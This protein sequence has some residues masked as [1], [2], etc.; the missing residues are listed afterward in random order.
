MNDVTIDPSPRPAQQRV[1]REPFVFSGST[2]EYFGIWIVN[3][4]L[5]IVTLGIYSAWAKVRRQRYFYGNTCLAGATFDYHA[6]PRQILVGR[7]AVVVLFLLYNGLTTVA[8]LAS[9]AVGV[10]FLF[11]VPWFI[12]RG[13][14]FNARVTSY[15]NVRFDFVGG[16][17]G[18]FLAYI[19]GGFLM[20]IS[21]GILAPL[22]SQWMWNY[23][24]GNVRYGGRPVRCEPRL[25]RLYGQWR[26][27]ALLF[28]GGLLALIVPIAAAFWAFIR[29]ED[30]TVDKWLWLGILVGNSPTLVV[31]GLLLLFA[32]AGLLYRAG[33]RNVAFN[34]TV[35]DGRH[36][37][38]SSIRR[39]RFA[40]ISVTNLLAT[41]FSLGLARPWAAIRMARYLSLVTAL[42][43]TGSLEDYAGSIE[44]SGSAVGAEYMDIEGFDLGF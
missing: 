42:D 24:L 12:M 39:R 2:R 44:Q 23:T 27:P 9:L 3:V 10:V 25:G 32:V 30:A 36:M 19:V 14:R 21:L 18:A 43:A 35:I 7:I 22:A 28:V 11:A 33:I 4:L 29:L 31:F 13:L 38:H 5:T 20:Y 37:L 34:E 41:V 26:L 16:Y 15:R 8:P 40:W 17:W 1:R 6:R